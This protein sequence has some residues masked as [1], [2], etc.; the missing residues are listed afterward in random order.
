[1]FYPTKN[2][3]IDEAKHPNEEEEEEEIDHYV[4]INEINF[5]SEDVNH[6]VKEVGCDTNKIV[7]T[8]TGVTKTAT[9]FCCII[10]SLFTA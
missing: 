2:L 5:P 6:S 9:I 10:S 3:S 7:K 8:S 4:N 1:M